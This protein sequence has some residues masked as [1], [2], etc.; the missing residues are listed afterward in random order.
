MWVLSLISLF[1]GIA[2]G[3][4]FKVLVLVPGSLLTLAAA[5]TGG[6]AASHTLSATALNAV[7]ALTSLQFGY[8]LGAI[9]RSALAAARARRANWHHTPVS[10]R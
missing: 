1:A 6:T 7:L 8:F 9:V 4:R 2:L 10:A 3:T 5:L